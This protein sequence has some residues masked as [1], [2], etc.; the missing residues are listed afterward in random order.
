MHRHTVYMECFEC[1]PTLLNPVAERTCFSQVVSC[2]PLNYIVTIANHA[3]GD[4]SGAKGINLKPIKTLRLFRLGKMLRLAKIKR[5]LEKYED[6][7]D[8]APFL[9]MVFTVFTI[10]FAAHLL[11][12][13]W[14]LAGTTGGQYESPSDWPI[15]EYGPIVPDVD[16]W[17]KQEF[18]D[19]WEHELIIRCED[20][21][22]DQESSARRFLQQK[23]DNRRRLRGGGG[24]S[25]GGDDDDGGGLSIEVQCGSG[26]GCTFTGA[27]L[28]TMFEAGGANSTI[29]WTYQPC[30]N[31]IDVYPIGT[32]YVKSMYS[33][34]KSEWAYSSNEFTVGVFSELVVGF[35]YGA[36]AATLGQLM[37]GMGAGEQE[38]QLK[39]ASIKGWMR[40]KDL[41]KGDQKKIIN[42]Y[43]AK[44][45]GNSIFDEVAI[46]DELPPA[47]AGDISFYM[48]GRYVQVLPM[49]SRLGQE[50][51]TR[52]CR[53]V[54]SLT[55]I[56]G[57]RIIEEGKVGSE[58]YFLLTGECEVLDR[59]GARPRVASRQ[60]AGGPLRRLAEPAGPEAH[61]R[62]RRRG[63]AR[64]PRRRLLLRGEPHRAGRHRQVRRGPLSRAPLPP[65]ISAAAPHRYAPPAVHSAPRPAKRLRFRSGGDDA[66]VRTRT[67]RATGDSGARR[68][69]RCD[70][71]GVSRTAFRELVD[72]K[73]QSFA[74]GRSR[75]LQTH[76]SGTPTPTRKSCRSRPG[77]LC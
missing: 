27:A 64:L 55:T 19:Y 51:L 35:I 60:L 46:L 66:D 68:M 25:P 44:N 63:A 47:M 71:S 65:G 52:L 5:M 14:F 69:L 20:E 58:M 33:I 31:L 30:L 72:G 59:N 42:Y 41:T 23:V 75:K 56:K 67:V 36:L 15:E 34:F 37:S 48:Y 11:A 9:G 62:P 45:K 24:G 18:P 7:F 16:G 61:A 77:L 74:G 13:F 40:A 57:Q 39:M 29:G 73:R 50:V 2:L 32:L 28:G 10:L 38:Y 1:L 12:C 26:D 3:N 22:T 43:R 6:Q 76:R 53:C 54:I 21:E 17:V 4:P 49:F 8:A 70:A